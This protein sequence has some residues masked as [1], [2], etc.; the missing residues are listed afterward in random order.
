M[1]SRSSVKRTTV[2]SQSVTSSA[3]S[4]TSSQRSSSPLSP[5]RFSRLQEKN[6]LCNLNDRLANYI[7]KVR[8]LENE[9]NRLTREVRTHEETKTREI[10]SVKS[11]YEGELSDA[12]KL[13]DE[14]SREKA[15]LELDIRRLYTENED[16]KSKLDK[17]TQDLL[18]AESNISSLEARVADLQKGYNQAQSD[19]KKFADEN[20][21][22]TKENQS[23]SMQLKESK[24]TAEEEI[25]KRVEAENLLQTTREELDFKEK[26]YRQELLETRT[27]Q[28]V[29]ISEIDGRLNQEYEEKLYSML[30]E[31]RAQFE[32]EL[33]RTKSE[34]SSMYEDKI[35]NLERQLSRN[36]NAAANAMEEMRKMTS[37][38]E[39]WQRKF[40]DLEATNSALSAQVRE[41]EKQLESDRNRH[42]A[43]ISRQERELARLHD[44]MQIRMQEYQD[45]MDIKVQLDMEIAAYRKLL[46]SEEE[47]LNITPVSGTPGRPANVSGRLTPGRRGTPSMARGGA[48]RKRT[49]LE[50]SETSSLQDYTITSSYKTDLEVVDVDPTGKFI[51]LHNKGAK[52]VLVGK[53]QVIARTF[54]GAQ[55][56]FKFRANSKVKAGEEVTIWSSDS[57]RDHEPPHH[58]VMAEQ[59]WTVSDQMTLQII[60][61]N[62]EEVGLLE[63]KR[64]QLSSSVSRTR[65]AGG[66]LYHQEGDGEGSERCAIM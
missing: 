65:Q 30:Q 45:L 9:N 23:L 52:E 11:M 31:V 36:S 25:L 32:D 20:K 66:E 6:E 34:T 3:G 38:Q 43:E 21:K 42:M 17:K 47:R 8:H 7:D 39:E 10:T 64:T 53:W 37:R 54:D 63:R 22:L 35:T 2:S 41:L 40:S 16:L 26:L 59:S 13:L 18:L 57:G 14:L 56:S 19:R 1:S 48:K 51:K 33:N 61:G 46:E 49:I 55:S 5:T 44:D 58:H 60:N 29:E 4:S 28:K 62:E 15:K 24:K 27:K 12:R 50:D